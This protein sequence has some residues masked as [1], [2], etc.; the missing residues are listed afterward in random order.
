[1]AVVG[2]EGASMIGAV[3]VRDRVVGAVVEGGGVAGLVFW[4]QIVL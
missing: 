2:V 3:V 1:V 4:E